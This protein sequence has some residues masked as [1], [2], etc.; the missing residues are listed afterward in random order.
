MFQTLPSRLN[1]N[2]F[3]EVAL[4]DRANKQTYEVVTFS[5]TTKPPGAEPLFSTRSSRKFQ[6][7][8]KDVAKRRR[9]CSVLYSHLS[10]PWSAVHRAWR[11]VRVSGQSACLP[12]GRGG[13]RDYS[14]TSII[15]AVLSR[16]RNAN[17]TE[18]R[19]IGFEEP[20]GLPHLRSFS[21]K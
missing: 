20:P 19:G 15:S 8:A 1:N 10:I 17:D 14:R 9:L 4:S 21:P 6:G 3:L 18:Q 16:R 13:S 7:H 2:G 5:E 12:A 11:G